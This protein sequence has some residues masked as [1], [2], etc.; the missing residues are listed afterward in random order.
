VKSCDDYL[1]IGLKEVTTDNAV[2]GGGIYDRVT[3]LVEH[4]RNPPNRNGGTMTIRGN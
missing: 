1:L 2:L 3:R 4:A